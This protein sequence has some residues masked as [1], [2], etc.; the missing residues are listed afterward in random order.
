MTTLSKVHDKIA[1]DFGADPNSR[2][3]LNAFWMNLKD[4]SDEDRRAVIDRLIE[5]DPRGLEERMKEFFKLGVK[6]V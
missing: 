1:S 3:S 2:E 4:L 6:S 5:A